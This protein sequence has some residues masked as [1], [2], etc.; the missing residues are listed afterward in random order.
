MATATAR[1]VE[2]TPVTEARRRA[3]RVTHAPGADAAVLDTE[4]APRRDAALTPD[5]K[6]AARVLPAPDLKHPAR[7][8]LGLVAKRA[9]RV[10]LVPGAENIQGAA[11]M[12]L[13]PDTEHAAQG[14]TTGTSLAHK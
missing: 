6:H 8:Q 4:S 7:V 2:D 1:A 9:A 12:L 14:L 10:Q 13:V 11:R 3:A 5:T